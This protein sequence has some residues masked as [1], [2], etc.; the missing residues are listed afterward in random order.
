MINAV[1]YAGLVGKCI[2][3]ER[4]ATETERAAPGN[5]ATISMEC[6]VAEVCD[7]SR[8]RVGIVADYGYI[9][10]IEPDTAATWKFRIW[11]DEAA[12]KLISS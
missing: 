1:M 2:C 6:T 9:F 4:P 7:E 3:M 5:P 12:R 8:G 11:P 10:T